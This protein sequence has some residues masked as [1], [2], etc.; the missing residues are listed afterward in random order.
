MSSAARKAANR[1]NA[2]KS[3]GPRSTAGKDRTRYNALRHGLSIAAAL[4]PTAA[5]RVKELTLALDQV[6]TG[7][8]EY[9]FAK[10]AAE[11]QVDIERVRQAKA[12]IVNK[13]A[14]RQSS[15]DLPL[16]EQVALGSQPGKKSC[17][18]GALR[19]PGALIAETMARKHAEEIA[20]SAVFNGS[21]ELKDLPA[22]S[23]CAP[24][25]PSVT[26]GP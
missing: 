20:V 8:G 7:Y 2:Q 15:T 16:T 23:E 3:T 17:Q 14:Q 1:R 11:A 10:V 24:C 25:A 26:R 22:T 21:S 13:A 18:A 9:D 6:T 19:A 12:A 4:D 5:D